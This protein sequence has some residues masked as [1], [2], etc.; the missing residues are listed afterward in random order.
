V[1]AIPTN[2]SADRPPAY[3]PHQRTAL[4]FVGTGTAGAYHAGVLRALHEAGVRVDLV[5]GQG[6]GAATAMFAAVDAGGRLWDA[7]GLWLS[8]RLLKPFYR[9]RPLWRV[10]AMLLGAVVLVLLLPLALWAV[11]GVA[12][13]LVLLAQLAAPEATRG[14]V[15]SYTALATRLVSGDLLSSVVP[16]LVTGLVVVLAGIILAAGLWGRRVRRRMRGPFLWRV[17]GAPLD[18]SAAMVQVGATFWQAI[19]GAAP[20]A[21]PDQ[22]DLSRRYSEL[23]ADSLGQPGYRELLVSVHDLDARRDLVFALLG[24]PYRSAF[25]GDGTTPPGRRRQEELVDLAALGRDHLADAVAGALVVPPVCEPHPMSFSAESYWR[26]ETHRLADRAGLVGR[27]LE[28]VS[29][30]GATQVV[31]VSAVPPLEGPHGLASP[32]LDARSRVGETVAAAETASVRE[33]LSAHGW[34]FHGVFEIRPAHNPLG[35]FDF[36]GGYDER[37]DRPFPI[38]ELM[39]RGYEDAY[40]QFIEPVVGAS[41]EQVAAAKPAASIDDLDLRPG[42]S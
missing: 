20:I 33:A 1:T 29:A 10:A 16:R 39:N 14:V 42:R 38:R 22:I 34:R 26:G 27:L 30:A 41:G 36:A 6:M 24:E 21:Q 11:L 31:V 13:P 9:W 23:L 8:P 18:A 15:S 19:R 17:L 2:A 35:P 5:A 40:R 28:E 37:S 32:R 12:Y 25:G 7:D 3:S 4:V